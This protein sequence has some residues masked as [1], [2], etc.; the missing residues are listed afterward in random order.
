MKLNIKKN[1]YTIKDRFT[2]GLCNLQKVKQ[3]P[4]GS[5][6]GCFDEGSINN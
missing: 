6:G 5:Q 2:N 1:E 3:P 4:R